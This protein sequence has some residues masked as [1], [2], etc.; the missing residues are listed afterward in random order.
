MDRRPNESRDKCTYDLNAKIELPTNI[1][2]VH[3]VLGFLRRMAKFAFGRVKSL[4]RS[5]FRDEKF[6]AQLRP[7]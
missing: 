1:F 7:S 4:G 2:F 6:V 3:A 5:N